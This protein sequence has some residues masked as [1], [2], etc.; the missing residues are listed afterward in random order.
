MSNKITNGFI[1]FIKS[2]VTSI[3]ER[4]K[5]EIYPKV[6]FRAPEQNVWGKTAP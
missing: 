4:D 5:V 3:L 6:L 1:A 2:C